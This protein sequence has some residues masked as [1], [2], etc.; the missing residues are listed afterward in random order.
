MAALATSMS[1]RNRQ[2]GD[3]TIVLEEN[4]NIPDTLL[5]PDDLYVRGV[6]VAL[7]SGNYN[8]IKDG[9]AVALNRLVAFLEREGAE[10]LVFSPT[11]KRPA[12]EPVGT[13]VSV[14]SVPIPRR[15]EYRIALGL[16]RSIRKQLAAFRPTLF[17][18]SAPDLLG[19]SA[20]RLA[21][22]WGVPAVASF[23]T[24]FD[25]YLRY[26]GLARLEKPAQRYLRHFYSLC[27]QVYVPSPSMA[28]V[29][30]DEGM[31]THLRMWGRGVDCTLFTPARRDLAWRKSW[32]IQDQDVVISFCGRLVRE[33][34]LEIFAA[35]LDRLRA[36]GVRH[37]T[38]IIGDGP[39]RDWLTQRLPEAIFTGFLTGEGLARAYASSD[40]F[41]FP[42]VT[43][44][45][46]IVTLEA[47]ATALP[48][49]CADSTGSSSLVARGSTGFLVPPGD[50]EQFASCL[51]RL[52]TGPELR[53]RMGRAGRIA[54][55]AH[56]WDSVMQ[57]LLGHYREVLAGYG[58]APAL[59][60]ASA[61]AGV[62]AYRSGEAL[63]SPDPS[64]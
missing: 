54:A 10:V 58:K 60:P 45:F 42:S 12:M 29:L 25:S 51:E 64:R 53:A 48:V 20:L 59:I 18:V 38:M 57:S 35:T 34:G 9:A 28:A 23:H 49:V 41:F 3:S 62:A 26:Y 4:R 33:K 39:E 36:R 15:S 52:A 13:V 44:T 37:R 47:M 8:N 50:I 31:A 19:Y 17:H 22:R 55:S 14:P 46:G 16:P 43:E 6:R 7:F 21:R 30:R 5:P 32:G 1:P 61:T 24:R 11:V 56:D 40:L 2:R 63:T 27:E